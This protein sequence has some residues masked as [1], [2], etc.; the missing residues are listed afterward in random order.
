MQENVRAL[1][2]WMDEDEAVRTLLGQRYPNPGEDI[3]TQRSIWQAAREHVVARESF[4]QTTPELGLI[5]AQLEPLQVQLAAR[6][7]IVAAFQQFNWTV[8]IAPLRSVLS[9]QKTVSE[10]AVERA[11]E[12][13]INDASAVFRFCLPDA[14]TPVPQTAQTDLDGKGLAI[15]SLNP[16][17]RVFGFGGGMQNGQNFLGFAYGFGTNVVQIAEYQGRWFV[18]DGYH[19][20]YG[21]LRRGVE[22]VPCVFIRARNTRELGLENPAFFRHEVLFGTHPPTLAD[23]LA[24]D[25]AR[26]VT[27]PATRKVIRFSAQEFQVEV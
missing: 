17:L 4:S 6:P 21:L 16:N 20:C 25:V 22:H 24:D 15:S 2:G 11:S 26:S 14:V 23:F 8:A 10:S 12:I 7:D 18:R 9:Y 5:P 13:D 19:R 27:R 3:T 1:I